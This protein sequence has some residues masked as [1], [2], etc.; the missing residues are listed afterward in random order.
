MPKPDKNDVSNG[1]ILRHKVLQKCS[2]FFQVDFG[3]GLDWKIELEVELSSISRYINK[4]C[5]SILY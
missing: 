2:N 1:F 4:N 5:V 3:H